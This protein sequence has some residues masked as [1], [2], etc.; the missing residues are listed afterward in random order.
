MPRARKRG[1]PPH[2]DLLTPGEWRAV[3]A[4]RHG[5][6]NAQIARRFGISLD[7]VKYHV[8]NAL[9]KLAFSGRARIRTWPGIPRDSV[10][11]GKE[12]DMDGI[13]RNGAIGQIARTVSDIAA[14]RRWYG[15]VLGLPHLYSFGTLAF[16]DCAGVRLMLSQ[17][18]RAAPESMIYFQVADIRTAHDTLSA[19]GVVFTH[20]PHLVHRHADGTEEWMAFFTDTDGRPLGIMSQA[21]PVEAAQTNGRSV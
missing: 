6:T 16:F 14:A 21:R 13:L 12:P 8:S 3:H 17:D 15:E 5:L 18:E 19:R 1:R 10:L 11:A 9:G 7:G 2:A 4:V 20:A